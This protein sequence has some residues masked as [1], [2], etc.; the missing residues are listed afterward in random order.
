MLT[1]RERDIAKLLLCAMGNEEIARAL[2]ISTDCVKHHMR[3]IA[4][5]AGITGKLNRVELAMKL[6]GAY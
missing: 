5:K 6:S 3:N 1:P 4:Y 2:K